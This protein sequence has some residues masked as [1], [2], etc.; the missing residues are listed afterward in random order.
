MRMTPGRTGDIAWW[1]R[2][3][4]EGSVVILVHSLGLDHTMWEEQ[5]RLLTPHRRVILADLPG[6]G[7]STAAPGEYDVAA[8]GGDLLAV[9]DD[10]GARSFELVGISIG[11]LVSL[12]MAVDAG[13]RVARL[14]AA[15]TAARLGSRELWSERI[16]AVVQG[17]MEGIREAVLSR[18]FAPASFEQQPEMVA[19]FSRVFSASDP[20]GYVGCCAALRDGDLTGMVEGITSPTLVIGGELDEATPPSHQEDL[21]ARIPGARLEVIAGASHIANLDRPEEFNRALAG[22]LLDAPA[23]SPG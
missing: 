16:A 4:P 7:R 21:A 8:I 3:D 6:H 12:W 5:V 13:D 1:D 15:N 22:F 23:Q 20:V 9:A 19:A 18:F 10:A 11:G 17:G 2:G 14:V